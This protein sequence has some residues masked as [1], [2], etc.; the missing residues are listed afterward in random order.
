MTKRAEKMACNWLMMTSSSDNNWPSGSSG[1]VTDKTTKSKL[2]ANH[3]P[4]PPM[5]ARLK[6][7]NLMILTCYCEIYTNQVGTILQ[8]FLQTMRS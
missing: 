3:E 7:K 5:A 1:R 8:V 4:H 6:R 2:K